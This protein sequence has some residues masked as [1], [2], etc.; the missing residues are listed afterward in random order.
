MLGSSN[1]QI[2]SSPSPVPNP[3]PKSK[4]Q[5]P[6]DRD[7]DWGWHYN[8]KYSLINYR[9]PLPL[10]LLPPHSMQCGN[11]GHLVVAPQFTAFRNDTTIHSR[12]SEP[13]IVS[14][15]QEQ[16]PRWWS[17]LWHKMCQKSS[18]L[19]MVQW[20]IQHH[21]HRKKTGKSCNVKIVLK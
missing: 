20:V 4:I 3:S 21:G 17:W 16:Q 9:W 18:L 15:R 1:L 8:P 10:L 13:V 5:S 2:L 12:Q 6:E 19:V 11:I 7:W 14:Q